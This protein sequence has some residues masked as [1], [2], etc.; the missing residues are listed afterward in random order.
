MMAGLKKSLD[1]A[2]CGEGAF[3]GNTEEFLDGLRKLPAR[4]ETGNKTARKAKPGKQARRKKS[5]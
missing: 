4:A 1:Q 5:H 2:R 3:Y